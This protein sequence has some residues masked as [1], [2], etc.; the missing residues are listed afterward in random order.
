MSSNPSFVGPQPLDDLAQIIAWNVGREYSSQKKDCRLL[1]ACIR[2][3]SGPNAE[4]LF[5]LHKAVA[6]L[7]PESRDPY[8]DALAD[9][10]SKRMEQGR[11]KN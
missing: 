2:S 11:L 3:A 6:E 4:Y 7:C 8:L 1:S 9:K 10:V 5:E